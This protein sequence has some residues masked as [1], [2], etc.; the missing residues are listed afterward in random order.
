MGF[1][2]VIHV[3][4]IE[5]SLKK[6]LQKMDPVTKLPAKHLKLLAVT[7][8]V[9]KSD[10]FEMPVMFLKKEMPEEGQLEISV[11]TTDLSIYLCH[12]SIIG[13]L[14][15]SQAAGIHIQKTL[16]RMAK[17]ANSE[18]AKT[19]NANIFASVIKEEDSSNESDNEEHKK[20]Q[21]DLSRFL[22]DNKFDENPEIPEL[23]KNLS[24]TSKSIIQEFDIITDNKKRKKQKDFIE[25]ESEL[26][27]PIN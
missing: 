27:S 26:F 6:Q 2:N 1:A 16:K 18:S 20:P 5:V 11:T 8:D 25:G 19:T 21:V 4:T 3:H 9:V 17:K 22:E 15:F 23:E 12:D 10:C 7:P 24:E 14:L 13:F